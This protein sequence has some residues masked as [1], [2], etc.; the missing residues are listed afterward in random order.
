MSEKTREHL[1]PF[2]ELIEEI[3]NAVLFVLMGLEVL[4]LT[5]TRR[6]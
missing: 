1:D 2:W 4:A 3:L 5:L 6:W